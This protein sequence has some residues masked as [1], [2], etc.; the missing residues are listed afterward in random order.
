MPESILSSTP[1]GLWGY[2]CCPSCGVLNL[3]ASGVLYRTR[4]AVGPFR[5][6][7]LSLGSI[8][9]ECSGVCGCL[10]GASSVRLEP[11]RGDACDDPNRG[12]E[13]VTGELYCDGISLVDG[14]PRMSA[15]AIPPALVPHIGIK[16]GSS[17]APEKF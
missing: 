7:T 13:V 8:F 11:V 14:S 3:C 4:S 1:L 9:L 5:F 17:R 12:P 15:I 6:V 10:N 2:S 16:D